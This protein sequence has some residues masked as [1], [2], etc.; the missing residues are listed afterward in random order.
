MS[1]FDVPVRIANPATGQN[2]LVDAIVDTGAVYSMVPASLLDGL[3]ITRKTHK[4]F[5]LADGTKKTYD[6]GEAQFEIQ[7]EERICPVVFGD[8]DVKLLGAVSLEIF[9]LIADTSNQ[10]LIPTPT[11]HLI[12]L[13]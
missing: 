1:M 7:S 13:R 2:I 8:K 11:L 4:E 6:I 3:G 10:E 12:G 5:T 9:G